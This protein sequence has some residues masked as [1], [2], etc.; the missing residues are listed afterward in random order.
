MHLRIIMGNGYSEWSGSDSIEY[1]VVSNT[2][3]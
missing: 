3:I 2:I 1:M